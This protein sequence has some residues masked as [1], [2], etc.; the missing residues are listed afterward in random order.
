MP[1]LHLDIGKSW[2]TDAPYRET[3]SAIALARNYGAI[4]VE[5]EAAALYAFSEMKRK[6]V[7]CY[8]HLTNTMAREGDDF[9]KGLENGSLASL[10]LISETINILQAQSNAL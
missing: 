10:K 9:E 8:A 4:A 6:P 2:T 1:H 5:M 3:A 7:I